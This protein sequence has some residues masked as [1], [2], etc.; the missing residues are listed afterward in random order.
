[1]K[2]WSVISR[3]EKEPSTVVLLQTKSGKH[4]LT[5]G[6]CKE[7]Y[8][9][10]I[11]V[12]LKQPLNTVEV[13]LEPGKA[14]RLLRIEG[15]TQKAAGWSLYELEVGKDYMAAL[16]LKGSSGLR[17]GEVVWGARLKSEGTQF[18]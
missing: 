4:F 7:A 3:P 15:N 2:S 9:K 6:P 16:A 12:G 14:A 11:G 13:S 5:A 10:A 17:L 18:P 1:M 8:L